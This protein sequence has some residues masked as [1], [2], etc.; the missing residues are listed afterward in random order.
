MMCHADLH[1][2]FSGM[3]VDTS[4][5]KMCKV[6]LFGNT[7]YGAF[8]DTTGKGENTFTNSAK[9]NILEI[10]VYSAV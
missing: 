5:G 9:F 7:K 8:K 1:I 10:E 6:W 3:E 2:S 4:N